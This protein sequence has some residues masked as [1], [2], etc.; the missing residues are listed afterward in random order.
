MT[1]LPLNSKTIQL[2]RIWSLKRV[3][4]RIDFWGLV[5]SVLN[6]GF[7]VEGEDEEDRGKMVI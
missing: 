5:E 1:I 6:L 3:E 2:L 7:L 4:C